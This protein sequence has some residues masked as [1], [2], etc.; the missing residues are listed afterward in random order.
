MSTNE[1]K[2]PAASRRPRSTE[3][4]S[5]TPS[6]R[7]KTRSGIDNVAKVSDDNPALDVQALVVLE[8]VTNLF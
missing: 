2:P 1:R 5:G 7:Q 6:P 8:A 4:D 3:R